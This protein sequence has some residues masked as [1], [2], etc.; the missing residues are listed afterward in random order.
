MTEYSITDYYYDGFSF[1]VVKNIYRQ[2][3][4]ARVFLD[5][6]M[7]NDWWCGYVFLPKYHIYYMKNY[8]DISIICHGGLTFGEDFAGTPSKNR[9]KFAIGFDFNHAG[10]NG[11]SQEL[12]FNECK[13]IIDQL[14]TITVQQIHITKQLS[15]E[16]IKK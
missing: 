10:D 7:C 4:I 9:G 11:G 13:K 8:D 2:P 12:V 16:E 3:N 1:S 5:G 14:N 6:V 15:P